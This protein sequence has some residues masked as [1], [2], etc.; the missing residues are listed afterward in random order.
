MTT[1]IIA[2]WKK[3]SSFE[4]P[5]V[6]P[7]LYHQLIGSLMYLVNARSDI[8]FAVKTLSE[9]MVKPQRVHQVVA[10]HVLRYLCGIVEYGLDYKREDGIYLS[11]YTNSDW[12]RCVAN[13]KITLRCFFSLGLATML[14]FSRKHN[15]VA[16]SSAKAEYMVASHVRCGSIQLCKLLIV[17]FGQEMRTTMIYCDNQSCIKIMENLVFHNRSKHREIR[18]HLIRDCVQRGVVELWYIYTKEKV[19]D[20]LM[21]SLGREKFNHFR[22]KFGVVKNTFL[23]KRDR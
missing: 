9:F 13:K 22:D 16:L 4:S 23:G 6:D 20:L 17:I 12:E 19:V 18:Y 2:N 10:K 1:P 5:L 7:T 11:S 3:L 21:K 14:W 15:F 8:C